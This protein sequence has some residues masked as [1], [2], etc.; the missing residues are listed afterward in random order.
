MFRVVSITIAVCLLPSALA[1]TDLLPITGVSP[2]LSYDVSA[3]TMS[4]ISRSW[5]RLGRPLWLSLDPTGYFTGRLQGDCILDWGDMTGGVTVGGLIFD[6]FTNSQ[7]SAGDNTVYVA[8]YQ[9]DNGWG[10]THKQIRALLRIE[11][12]PGS[13]HPL[14]EYW[15]RTIEITPIEFLIDGDDLDGDGLDDFSYAFH[16]ATIRTPHARMGPS[17]AG[18]VDPNYMPPSCPGVVSAF[19][20]Y[21][22]P[23]WINDPNLAT[24]YVGT[25]WF[26]GPPFA[27]FYFGLYAPSCCT[28]GDSN[29]YCIGDIGNFNC[30]VDLADLA[31]LLA[32]YGQSR[33]WFPDGDIYPPDPYAPGDG[34]IDLNDLAAL[35]AQYGDDCR[36]GE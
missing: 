24:T 8:V 20:R 26:P 10:D 32:H 34:V 28:P 2:M 4:P 9:N 17:I 18:V 29:N 15:G 13:T 5:P 23:D 14:N 35:L 31:Q 30:V 3:Q 19:D 27:Q 12:I 25:Y 16:Y 22:D 1:D 7:A 21:P 6:E 11:N 33:V 36:A